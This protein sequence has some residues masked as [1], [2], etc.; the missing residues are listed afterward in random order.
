M[1][2]TH[3][4]TNPFIHSESN[5]PVAPQLKTVR[6]LISWLP[7]KT[8]AVGRPSVPHAPSPFHPTPQAPTVVS[9]LWVT[10]HAN[11]AV[12]NVISLIVQTTKPPQA[13]PLPYIFLRSLMRSYFVPFACGSEFVTPVWH[14]C[15][16]LHCISCSSSFSCWKLCSLRVLPMCRGRTPNV[17]LTE[18]GGTQQPLYYF[19]CTPGV[20]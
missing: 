1:H 4:F 12:R 13:P 18:F 11:P 20:H 8:H 16:T 15:V 7:R 14:Y 17:L 10:L 3:S 2:I 9:C 5:G 19:N 6:Q